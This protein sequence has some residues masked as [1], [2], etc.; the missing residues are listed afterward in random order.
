MHL[1]FADVAW[2]GMLQAVFLEGAEEVDGDALMSELDQLA[3][4]VGAEAEGEDVSDVLGID[5]LLLEFDDRVGREL[6]IPACAIP[7]MKSGPT[8]WILSSMMSSTERSP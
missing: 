6:P 7:V 3:R 8:P 2:G 4:C 5:A 1:R